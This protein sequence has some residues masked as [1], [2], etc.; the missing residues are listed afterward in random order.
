MIA[1]HLAKQNNE[2][3]NNM[4]IVLVSFDLLFLSIVIL[5]R[6]EINCELPLGRKEERIIMVVSGKE[7]G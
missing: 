1:C 7:K 3:N 6:A 2:K 4:G 5:I